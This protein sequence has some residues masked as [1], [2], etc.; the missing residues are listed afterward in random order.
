MELTSNEILKIVA[1]SLRTLDD[2]SKGK[3]APSPEVEKP[4]PTGRGVRTVK[5]APG[6][7][8]AFNRRGRSSWQPGIKPKPA[9]DVEAVALR[10]QDNLDAA[11]KKRFG[12][13]PDLVRAIANDILRASGKG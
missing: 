13:E 2:V 9:L 1:A 3:V 10:L 7:V 5:P 6:E 11:L 4:K 8:E 12:S